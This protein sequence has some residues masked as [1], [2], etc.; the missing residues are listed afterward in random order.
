MSLN[1]EKPSRRIG[2]NSV[3][4]QQQIEMDRARA[5]DWIRIIP[6]SMRARPAA[7][8]PLSLFVYSSLIYLVAV[9]MF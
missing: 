2:K 7:G 5:L 6:R 4:K 9:L 1:F 8:W 3:Q